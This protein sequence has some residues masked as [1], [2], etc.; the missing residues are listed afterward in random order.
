MTRLYCLTCCL[1]A[2]LLTAGAASAQITITRTDIEN[3]F[4]NSVRTDYGHDYTFGSFPS[5]NLGNAA[6][7][8]QTFDFSAL[9]AGDMS[10]DTSTENYVPA[11]GAPGFSEF[12]SSNLAS[13]YEFIPAPGSSLTLVTFYSIENDGLYMLGSYAHQYF[14]PFL[15]TTQTSKYMPK[16]LLFPLPLTYGTTR[17]FTDTMINDASTGEYEVTTRTFHCN[18]Y[19]AITF[20]PN[21]AMPVLKSTG[22]EQT[23]RV[24]TDDVIHVYDG[25]NSLI[26]YGHNREIDF[27]S[28]STTVLTFSVDDTNYTSGSS[29]VSRRNMNMKTGT[30]GVLPAPAG[31]PGNFALSQN[32]PN[33]FNPATKITFAVPTEQFVTLRVYDILGR[34][35]AT[36]L[37]DEMG[38]GSYTV[39]FNAANLAGGLYVCRLTA[40]TY[41]ATMKMSLVK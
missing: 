30:T 10:R 6:A 13:V 29:G 14:P 19:G 11:S 18:G 16:R 20:P 28:A 3:G 2:T 1:I 32:Y 37:N 35:V 8:S 9:P 27:A 39:D 33:P 12:P 34:E 41:V 17:S 24:Q 40:G 15:D 36:L 25:S 31:V 21:A 7:G 5:M 22:S 4:L 23:L 26:A 38:A